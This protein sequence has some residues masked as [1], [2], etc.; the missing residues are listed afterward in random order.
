MLDL[1]NLLQLAT[2]EAGF[3]DRECQILIEQSDERAKTLGAK[4]FNRLKIQAEHDLDLIQKA[5]VF[6]IFKAWV[7]HRKSYKLQNKGIFTGSN[8]NGSEVS[9]LE[10]SLNFCNKLVDPDEEL[11]VTYKYFMRWKRHFKQCEENIQHDRFSEIQ[12]KAIVLSKQISTQKEYNKVAEDWLTN[13]VTHNE[14][15]NCRFTIARRYI[16]K[17]LGHRLT[18][19]MRPFFST[20]KQ[21]MKR[22]KILDQKDKLIDLDKEQMIIPHRTE[23]YKELNEKL[24]TNRDKYTHKLDRLKELEQ[25]VATLIREIKIAVSALEI[26]F[27][28]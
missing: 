28:Y 21:T 24:M 10:L 12:D 26:N 15:L 23:Q 1:E 2:A 4:Y 17:H 20:W 6:D 8:L 27:S 7:K 11:A 9:S 22:L 13:L 19:K 5:H 14:Q 25:Q 16:I 18:E 3:T